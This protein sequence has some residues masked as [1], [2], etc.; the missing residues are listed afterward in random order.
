M[1]Y[2]PPLGP[3]RDE[4]ELLRRARALAGWS[5]S[6]LADSLGHSVPLDATRAKG[7]VGQLIEDALGAAAGNRA[8]P[9]FERLGVELKT[10]PVDARGHP[11]ESTYVTTLPLAELDSTTFAQSS[12]H[13]KLAAVLFVPVEADPKLPLG[14]RQVGS[15][16]L[17]RP[18]ASVW[19]LIESDWSRFSAEVRAGRV[20][21]IGPKVGELLQVRPKGADAR[22]TTR[23][24]DA[25]GRE[26]RTMRRG[27]YLRPTFVLSLF[28]GH[29]HMPPVSAPIGR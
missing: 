4:G 3:P 8:V 24:I 15:P 27:L 5:L 25:E 19:A 10:V 21:H 1:T 13:K 26:R 7:W 17:W 11:R 22:E 6:S 12:L 9:D 23:T 2:S 29:F 20:E 16:F 28:R 14:V 18:D